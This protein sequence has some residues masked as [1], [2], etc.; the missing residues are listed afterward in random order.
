[1][2]TVAPNTSA[3]STPGKI[4][5][6]T[7]HPEREDA[8]SDDG[9]LWPESTMRLEELHRLATPLTIPETED[10][11]WAQ[12]IP[13][14][15]DRTPLDVP[16]PTLPQIPVP[17]PPD[18]PLNQNRPRIPE[19]PKLIKI[20][21]AEQ[22][23][24]RLRRESYVMF[25]KKKHEQHVQPPQ[26]R[27]VLR[28]LPLTD[29]PLYVPPDRLED[30][31]MASNDCAAVEEWVNVHL[32]KGMT[33][34]IPISDAYEAADD[35]KPQRA[36]YHEKLEY[37][38]ASQLNVISCS[39]KSPLQGA[40]IDSASLLRLGLP[41]QLVERIY[42]GLFVYTSGFHTLIHDIGRHC[43]AYAESHIAANVWLAF[44]HL[45]EKCE[46]GRYEMAMLK[47]NHA[48]SIWK[49][50]KMQEY[51]KEK[52][53]LH[54]ELTKTQ[55]ELQVEKAIVV[56]RSHEL[57]EQAEAMRLVQVEMKQ[58]QDKFGD[59]ED[60]I[61]LHK[62]EIM[63]LEDQYAKK[64][65]EQ[66]QTSNALSLALTEKSDVQNKVDNY[67]AQIAMAEG[68]ISNHETHKVRSANRIREL[69]SN[70]QALRDQIEAL[71]NDVRMLTM[72]KTKLTSDRTMLSEK[73]A[74]LEIEVEGLKAHAASLENLNKS[75]KHDLEERD[76]TILSLKAA[77]EKDRNAFV[78]HESEIARLTALT[79]KQKLDYGVLE[80]QA[81]LLIIEKKNATQK[82]AD[83]A[84]IER[85]LNKKVELEQEMDLLRQDKEQGQEQIWNLRASIDTLE[86]DLHHS[87]RAYA[88]SQTSLAQAERICE[89]MRGQLQEMERA[90]DRLTQTLATQKQQSKL[91]DDASR[92]QVDKM[93]MELRVVMGQMREMVYTRRENE[94]QIN[95]LSKSL[96]ASAIELRMCKQRVEKGDK[97][98]AAMT[99]ERDTLLRDKRIAQL[100]HSTNQAM[101]NRLNQAT[102]QLMEKIRLNEMNYDEAMEELKMHYD[103]AFAPPP[104]LITSASGVDLHS[105]VQ[106]KHHRPQHANTSKNMQSS[107]SGLFD[108][109][110]MQAAG[111]AG[112]D[113]G[114]IGKGRSPGLHRIPS[115]ARGGLQRRRSLKGGAIPS[116]AEFT[117]TVMTAKMKHRDATIAKL[118]EN[119]EDLRFSLHME[120]NT[121][122]KE[123]ERIEMMQELLKMADEDLTTHKCV[124]KRRHVALSMHCHRVETDLKNEKDLVRLLRGYIQDL[125]TNLN[126][127]GIHAEDARGSLMIL[128]HKFITRVDEEIQATEDMRDNSTQ[129][130]PPRR[131][132]IKERAKLKNSTFSPETTAIDVLNNIT[133]ILPDE[134][135]DQEFFSLTHHGIAASREFKHSHYL[136]SQRQARFHALPQL[137]PAVHHKERDRTGDQV[138][139]NISREF[140]NGFGYVER[141]ADANVAPFVYDKRRPR[142][143]D[144]LTVVEKLARELQMQEN[145][146]LNLTQYIS[147]NDYGN[148]KTSVARPPG[149]PSPRTMGP[150]PHIY[151]GAKHA[152]RHMK[153]TIDPARVESGINKMPMMPPKP[154]KPRQIK[155]KRTDATISPQNEV[156]AAVLLLE[157]LK[158]REHT[159]P[160]TPELGKRREPQYDDDDESDGDSAGLDDFFVEEGGVLKRRS[161][162]RVPTL[163]EQKVKEMRETEAL[164]EATSPTKHLVGWEL[165][166]SQD[167]D[168]ATNLP[169]I[170]YP[171]TKS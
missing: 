60:E 52:E 79:H 10:F 161:T 64:S 5:P 44:L 140:R 150:V 43:P 49:K 82:E 40:G 25:V 74:S 155:H 105:S 37:S 58:T 62:M 146:R 66:I 7:P 69:Q 121:V 91:L 119:L 102:A 30:E 33:Q 8:E 1:M 148:G 94:A 165:S 53:T 67:K 159:T 61:R 97:S 63:H 139:A 22:E 70:S 168:A 142:A 144:E 51:E 170:L 73:S 2:E 114:E 47:F 115:S 4:S 171:L 42:R 28:E 12:E 162:E 141:V 125:K 123:R 111:G 133:D 3:H 169:P 75:Q 158:E 101:V 6:E 71:K 88:S 166:R 130:Y 38:D 124:A 59:Y 128:R 20:P 24:T 14:N 41:K 56:K 21:P 77:M 107:V 46:D 167:K 137:S 138:H 15:A 54:T 120:K 50:N 39:K 136:D 149:R 127:L 55:D 164:R 80:A 36:M 151:N 160:Y 126:H 45:L 27:N 118:E 110:V 135:L 16:D 131:S 122:A 96:E 163:L 31:V 129:T 90:N 29:I 68:K 72:D 13:R 57:A 147:E 87:K 76:A 19:K 48:T 93:E 9:I 156:D 103:N 145:E 85:L 100:E 81:Q 11:P 86:N 134:E 23:I 112:G 95:D 104:S 83:K 78:A 99:F 153:S 34:L 113:G 108:L 154:K 89:H 17:V 32:T 98:L 109:M 117:I 65:D 18:T 106:A 84:R 132:P 157:A 152:P 143:H 92:E 35:P 116:Q 26:A